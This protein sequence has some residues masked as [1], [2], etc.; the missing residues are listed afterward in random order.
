[1]LR[2]NVPFVFVPAAGLR[3]AV[4]GL[5]PPA[6]GAAAAPPPALE[7]KFG[8]LLA[9]VGAAA[10]REV[11]MAARGVGEVACV[12]FLYRGLVVAASSRVRPSDGLLEVEAG[13]GD[14]LMRASAFSEAALRKSA[15]AA[16]ARAAARAARGPRSSA[17]R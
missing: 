15:E 9:E 5:V 1:M 3:L 14:P 8:R 12:Q 4:R 11:A 16:R 2:I 17:R 13:L 10:F 6:A 7:R